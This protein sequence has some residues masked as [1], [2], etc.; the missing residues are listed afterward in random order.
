MGVSTKLSMILTA[1]GAK[2]VAADIDNVDGK[3][4]K[5]DKSSK[6]TEKSSAKVAGRW[7][8]LGAAGKVGAAGAAA[9]GLKLGKDALAEYREA[10]K[11]GKQTNAVIE[12]TGG[13]AGLSAKHVGDLAESISNKTAVDDEEIQKASNMLLT[14]K[15]IRNEAGKNNAVFDRATAAAVDLSASGFGSIK[16][17]SVMLGKALNDPL[18]GM[19]ALGKSGVTFTAG[20]KKQVEAMVKAGDLLGAQKVIM[21]EVEGQ[22][23]GSADAQADPL[24]RLNTR[25]NNI[26]ETA[27][28]K[29]M[30]A[31]T[32]LTGFIL[33]TLL[34]GIGNVTKFIQKNK[35]VIIPLVAVVGS[36]IAAWKIYTT[37]MRIAAAVQ[38]A[39]NTVMALNPIGLVVIAV[40]GL[41]AALIIAYK[42]VGWFRAGVQA[43]GRAVVG[44]FNWVVTAVKK[45]LAFIGKHWKTILMI[46]TGPLGAAVILIA[47]NFNK[48]V[49]F[50]K[51][52]PGRVGRAL[53][54]LWDGIKN[55]FKGAINWIIRKWNSFSLSIG[56]IKIPA[57]PDIPK[58][59]VNT[60]NIPLF[61]AGGEAKGV[62][63]RWI[64]GEDGPEIGEVTSSGV[65]ITP[66]G[67]GGGSS[68]EL[69]IQMD[70][71][72]DGRK[73][74]TGLRRVALRD[75]L[76]AQ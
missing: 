33:N 16:S 38:L 6:A 15:Q 17:A 63:A 76:A 36:M 61:A 7:K 43:V 52:L 11:V 55:T 27:G 64:S 34:P 65:R 41:I 44:A 3:I 8:Q 13:V 39:F 50:A 53:S 59:S 45:V 72:L 37:I 4:K 47:S 70:V 62:G 22:V 68:P 25:W 14:F 69:V 23:K 10:Y 26:L 56:P 2:R 60:P 40:V 24:D 9:L 12:A 1:K 75:L 71:N 32:A 19:T 58:V 42:R 29:L 74:G 67:D 5:I 20:Q 54:G 28:T 48:I 49:R 66:L 46:L 51:S 57:A 21:K 35:D 18:K 31:L 30:P 73:V